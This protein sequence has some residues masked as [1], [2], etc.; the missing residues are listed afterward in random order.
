MRVDEINIGECEIVTTEG[1]LFRST[2]PEMIVSDQLISRM[3]FISVFH[4]ENFNA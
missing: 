4:G 1:Q 2:N 3:S